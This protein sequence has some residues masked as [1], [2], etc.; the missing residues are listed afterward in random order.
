MTRSR[1]LR[2]GLC[3]AV[4]LS[5]GA[6]L[7]CLHPSP[8]VV[9]HTLQPMP[10]PPPVAGG[11]AAIG[12]AAVPALEVLPVRLP[13]LLRRPQMVLSEGGDALGLSETHRWGNPL[14]QDMQRVLVADLGLLRPGGPVVPSPDGARVAAAL[15]LEVTVQSCVGRPGQGLVLQATWMVTRTG[16]DRALLF[17]RTELREPLDPPGPDGLAAAH[18]RILAALARQIATALAELP[19]SQS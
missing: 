12:S 6:G 15:R 17:R 8:A 9:Y 16:Q 4:A 10:P 5:L 3:L 7:A 11:S 13:D 1:P 14:E 2:P 19:A 18:S